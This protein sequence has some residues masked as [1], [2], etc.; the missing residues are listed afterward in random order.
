M[1]FKLLL[2]QLLYF[3]LTF[4]IIVSYVRVLAKNS[5]TL[6]QDLILENFSPH[7]NANYTEFWDTLQESY[8]IVVEKDKFDDMWVDR[9]NKRVLKPNAF[10]IC[11]NKIFEILKDQS[12]NK[13]APLALT[14]VWDIKKLLMDE[15]LLRKRASDDRLVVICNTDDLADFFARCKDDDCIS[16]MSITR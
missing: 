5:G 1:F 12:E 8:N 14:V 13:D 9:N 16:D 10:N 3:I 11:D 2:L 15:K 4:L 6:C 7:T